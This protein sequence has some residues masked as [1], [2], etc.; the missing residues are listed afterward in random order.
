MHLLRI[1]I[2][3]ASCQILGVTIPA[4]KEIENLLCEKSGQHEIVGEV[5][6]VL[7]EKTAGSLVSRVIK[8]FSVAEAEN[9]RQASKTLRPEKQWGLGWQMCSLELYF[10]VMLGED[11]TE[12]N[13]KVKRQF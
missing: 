12:A 8:K 10:W 7:W 11:I 9:V 3:W 2:C 1:I 5:F 4:L 6:K 13:M